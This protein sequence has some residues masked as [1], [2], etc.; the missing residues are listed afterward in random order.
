MSEK[1]TRRIIAT[2]PMNDGSLRAKCPVFFLYYQRNPALF[3]GAKKLPPAG[4][5]RNGVYAAPGAAKRQRFSRSWMS[6]AMSFSVSKPERS[7]PAPIS[8]AISARLI[9]VRL[10]LD[11]VFVRISRQRRSRKSTWPGGRMTV[12]LFV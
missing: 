4:F 11:R 5:Q 2:G 3:Y 12:S 10:T 1:R 7:S 9:S 8:P 6:A